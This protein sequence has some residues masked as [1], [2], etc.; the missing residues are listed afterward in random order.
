M[1]INRD[2][3]SQQIY[4]ELKQKILQQEYKSGQQLCI[5]TLA[6]Y[7]NISSMPIRDALNKLD[8]EGL[9]KKKPRVGYY[10]KSYNAQEVQDIMETRKMFE[11][12]C[13]DNHFQ[14]IK[15]EKIAALLKKI[16]ETN[17]Y[18]RA[19]FNDLDID[20]HDEIIN[21]SNNSYLIERFSRI[22]ELVMIFRY[23]DIAG[24]RKANQYHEWIMEAILADDKS[25]TRQ[26]L[27]D[28][29]DN[30]TKSVLIYLARAKENI[31]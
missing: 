29:I 13:I 16:R 11:L 8:V 22:R 23:L 17:S 12:Y 28:H 2:N 18:N 6:E 27:S 4:K 3:I 31:D 25:K 26:I 20:F 5:R 24:M 9:I 10:V 7:Y 21:A 30:A 14:G 15:K 19:Q 1:G